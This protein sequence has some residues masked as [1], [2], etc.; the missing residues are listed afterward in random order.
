MGK[1]KIPI[2]NIF[3]PSCSVLVW[4]TSFQDLKSTNVVA[5]ST[6][7]NVICNLVDAEKIP[8]LLPFIV[9]ALKD[10]R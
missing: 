9:A 1:W 2:P 5:K 4:C 8:P 6:V 3:F 10:K 7:L